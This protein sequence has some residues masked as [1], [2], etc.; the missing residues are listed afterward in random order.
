[1]TSPALATHFPS[2]LG[3]RLRSPVLHLVNQQ[4][5]MDVA[6]SQCQRRAN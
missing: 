3:L 1:M 5:A 2:S 4:I 6:N